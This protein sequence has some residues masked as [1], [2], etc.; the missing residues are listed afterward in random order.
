MKY[1][2]SLYS[3]LTGKPTVGGLMDLCD[4]NYH[5]LLRLSPAIRELSGCYCSEVNGHIDLYLDVLE[6]T[7]YTTLVHLTYYFPQQGG[8]TPDPDAT[9][10][11]Y[12]DS[13]QAEV[14]DLL[15]SALPL[16]RGLHNP[17]LEQKW[18]A[19]M[20]LSKWLFFCVQQKHCFR[21]VCAQSARLAD[22]S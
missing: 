1:P 2:W 3:L 5:H 8:S 6:Q 18:R 21:P 10:R 17:T 12:H 19:N 16:K 14:L 13:R 15:Q 4:E 22:S 20:F 9:V 11:I 7:S